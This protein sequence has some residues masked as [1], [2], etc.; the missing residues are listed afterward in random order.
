SKKEKAYIRYE[1]APAEQCQI[2]WGYFG[3]LKYGQYHRKVW[4]FAMIES[5]SRMLYLEFTHSCKMDLFIGCHIRAF[6]FFEGTP[7][8]ILHDNLKTAVIER[9]GRLVRFNERYLDF[10]RAHHIVPNA[11]NPYQ[12]QEKGKIEKGGIH[13]IRNNFWPLREFKDIND[14]NEQASKWR[15]EIANV[16][17]QQ[18][19]QDKPVNRYQQIRMRPFLKDCIDHRETKFKKVYRDC[20]IWFDCNYYGVPYGVVGKEVTVKADNQ[21]VIIYYKTQVLARHERCWEKHKGIDNPNHI[22]DL[23]KNKTRAFASK[24]QEYF[25]CLDP[26]AQEYL[27]ALNNAN[28]PVKKNIQHLLKLKDE[29]GA[30]ALIFAC[31]AAIKHNALGADYVENILLQQRA[32]AATYLPVVMKQ[33]EY[34]SLIITEADL[35]FYDNLIFTNNKEEK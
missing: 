13:Y 35:A 9:D 18:T 3:T 12:P 29:Y 1:S 8:E 31:K 23:L 17:I 27:D 19:I 10:L 16:R 20:R 15:D 14:L 4:C 30:H 2:D 33:E 21:E 34:N 6:N 22:K 32:P 7:K 28:L 25:L 24:Q 5:Y 26:F 11:C